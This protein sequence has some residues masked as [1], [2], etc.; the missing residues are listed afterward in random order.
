[1]I[2][3]EAGRVGRLQERQPLLVELPDWSRS[4]VDP[5][6]EPNEMAMVSSKAVELVNPLELRSREGL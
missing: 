3:V 1:M 4:P 5:I 2:A 6:E